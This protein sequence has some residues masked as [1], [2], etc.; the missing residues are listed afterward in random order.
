MADIDE[1]SV[2]QDIGKVMGG[3]VRID[4]SDRTPQEISQ[5]LANLPRISEVVLGD[6]LRWKGIVRELEKLEEH[7][8]ALT[9]KV[10][11]M[12][13]KLSAFERKL[14]ERQHAD[15][16]ASWTIRILIGLAILSLVVQLWP[17]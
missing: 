12:E 11:S 13:T 4:V 14:G 9:I 5:I 1:V 15:L 7:I 3:S 6:G 17:T 2:T 16:G 8:R 10:D